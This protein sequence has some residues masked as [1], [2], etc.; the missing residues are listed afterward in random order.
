[1][2]FDM[3]EG[4]FD[5][6]LEVNEQQPQPLEPSQAAAPLAEPVRSMP[7]VVEQLARKLALASGEEPDEQPYPLRFPRWRYH[8][9][10][11]K[12][13]LS[14]TPSEY[15]ALAAVLNGPGPTEAGDE[16]PR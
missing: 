5:Y 6:L 16:H 8:Y 2:T 3:T 1:M 14:I 9:A 7:E 15:G 12:A 11:A 4:E 10:R 13:L